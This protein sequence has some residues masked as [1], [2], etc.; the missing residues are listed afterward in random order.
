MYIDDGL[1]RATKVA[2]ARSGKHEY[3]IFEEALREHLGL[4][5]VVERIWSGIPTES[6]PDEDEAA[7]IVAEELAAVRGAANRRAG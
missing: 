4:A 1:L 3:E 5:G 7:R 2:A 6:A